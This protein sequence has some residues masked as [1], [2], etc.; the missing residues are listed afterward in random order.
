MLEMSGCNRE[1]GMTNTSRIFS[2]RRARSSRMLAT[3]AVGACV[4]LAGSQAAFA[5]E[6]QPSDPPAIDCA[7]VRLHVAEHGRAKSI[8]WAVK[9]GFSWAQIA[10]AR[11]CLKG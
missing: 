5:K 6:V 9:N 10:A 7:T 8:T 11:R 2:G 3:F 4:V 1:G